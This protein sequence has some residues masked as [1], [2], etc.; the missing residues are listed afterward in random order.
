MVPVPN[1]S[2]MA[3]PRRPASDRPRLAGRPLPRV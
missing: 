1:G 3:P 2:V